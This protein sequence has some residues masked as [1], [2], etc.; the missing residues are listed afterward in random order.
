MS[1]G[2]QYPPISCNEI[3]W[4]LPVT[5]KLFARGDPIY[6]HRVNHSATPLKNKIQIK[7]N[8]KR[9]IVL[10][11]IEGS[12]PNNALFLLH[13]QLLFFSKDLGLIQ[14]NLGLIFILISNIGHV[15]VH[16]YVRVHVHVRVIVYVWFHSGTWK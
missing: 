14:S 16:F 1:D 4:E 9:W 13:Q 2:C 6:R 8:E 7:K 5:S 15:H 10:N 12:S 3:A 11:N